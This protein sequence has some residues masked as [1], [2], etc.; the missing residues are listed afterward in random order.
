MGRI[1]ITS[2][3]EIVSRKTKFSLAQS[4]MK[5]ISTTMDYHGLARKTLLVS[6]LPSDFSGDNHINII[7]E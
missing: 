5:P 4:M 6:Q 1:F 7:E 3:N 2:N